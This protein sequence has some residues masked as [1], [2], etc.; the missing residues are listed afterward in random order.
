MVRFPQRQEA[1]RIELSALGII[2]FVYLAIPYVV[3]HASSLFWTFFLDFF[4]DFFWPF[5]GPFLTFFDLFWTF[6]DSFSEEF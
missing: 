3:S 5:F 6:L 1:R 4:L 2:F